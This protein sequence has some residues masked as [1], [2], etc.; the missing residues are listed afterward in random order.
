MIPNL[1]L[2]ELIAGDRMREARAWA[3]QRHL[4][5]SLGPA[6][7]PFRVTL[8]LTLIRMGHWLADRRASG[9]ARARVTA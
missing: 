8:G 1:H 2:A 6:V 7:T 5:K 3:A 4:V 9:P